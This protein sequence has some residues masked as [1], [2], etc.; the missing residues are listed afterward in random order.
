MR[1]QTR[2][3]NGACGG[4]TS[5]G[6]TKPLRRQRMVVRVKKITQ[7]CY[8]KFYGLDVFAAIILPKQNYLISN[9]PAS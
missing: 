2:F 4:C 3:V 1:E 7:G 8:R 6:H 9:N 5:V